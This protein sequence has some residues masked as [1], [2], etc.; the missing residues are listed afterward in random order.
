MI[1]LRAEVEADRLQVTIASTYQDD[2][3]AALVRPVVLGEI[4]GR[5]RALDRDLISMGVDPA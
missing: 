2:A 3:M 1:K 5:I 4:N